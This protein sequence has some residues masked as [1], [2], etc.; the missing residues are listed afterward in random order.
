ME[1]TTLIATLAIM[2][3]TMIPVTTQAQ[4]H[5]SR[6][7]QRESVNVG[8]SPYV[9]PKFWWNMPTVRPN[10]S[11]VITSTTTRDPCVFHQH[12]SRVQRRLRQPCVR[13]VLFYQ[14]FRVGS[15]Q[16]STVH[17]CSNDHQPSIRLPRLRDR[18]VQPGNPSLRVQRPADLVL[19]FLA[20][21]LRL[22]RLLKDQL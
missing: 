15:F 10:V 22:L 19:G 12:L 11:P 3:T 1:T 16:E 7:S 14:Q 5:F 6:D 21:Q 8:F 20:Q 2:T 13:L 17:P 18:Q 4:V 9:N